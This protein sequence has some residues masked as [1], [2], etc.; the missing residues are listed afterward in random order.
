RY[1]VT[2]KGRKTPVYVDQ[3]DFVRGDQPDPQ[4][5]YVLGGYKLKKEDCLW[6]EQNEALFEARLEAC[7]KA[8]KPE[9]E[10]KD[11]EVARKEV[12]G[13]RPLVW[14]RGRRGVEA[15][16]RSGREARRRQRWLS[17]RASLERWKAITA[18]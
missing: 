9:F 14:Q 11:Y 1:S 16:R 13:L 5:Q 12:L 3:S 10:G 15:G 6:V 7:Q 18:P 8:R 17:P 4:P 2:L